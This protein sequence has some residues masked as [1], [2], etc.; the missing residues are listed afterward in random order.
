[1]S[2]LSKPWAYIKSIFTDD[3]E[4]VL[5]SFLHLFSTDEGKLILTT[6]IAEAPA[7]ATSNWAVVAADVISKVISQSK[8]IASQDAVVT[9]TQVQSALQ[10]AKAA[11]SIVTPGDQAQLTAVTNAVAALPIAPPVTAQ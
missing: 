10:I 4:P 6:A 3:V 2:F 8:I 7:L 5:G 9:L 1:M 11:A